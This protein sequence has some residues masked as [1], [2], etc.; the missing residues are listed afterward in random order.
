M[1]AALVDPTAAEVLDRTDE[2]VEL[3]GG[4]RC[5]SINM[6]IPRHINIFICGRGPD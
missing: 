2:S 3:L 4:E 6:L 1:V 5:G